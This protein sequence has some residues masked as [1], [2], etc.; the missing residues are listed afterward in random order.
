MKKITTIEKT[1]EDAEKFAIIGS[2]I[3]NEIKESIEE[4][5]ES[6]KEFIEETIQAMPEPKQP[7]WTLKKIIVLVAIGAVIELSAIIFIAQ[8]AL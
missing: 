6:I 5:E 3:C 8:K 4:S 1:M 7:F 2:L